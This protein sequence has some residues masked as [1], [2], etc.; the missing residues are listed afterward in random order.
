MGLFMYLS[1]VW[2]RV[3]LVR[4]WSYLF[5]LDQSFETFSA[6]LYSEDWNSQ[7]FYMLV[8]MDLLSCCLSLEILSTNLCNNILTHQESRISPEPWSHWLQ[9]WQQRLAKTQLTSNLVSSN[10][11]TS[12][13]ERN[14][15]PVFSCSLHHG[16]HY[17]QRNSFSSW[18]SM[19]ETLSL[20]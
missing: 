12:L 18:N 11:S 16:P 6:F 13:S 2:S 7:N 14:L 20:I 10:S 1:T 15:Q 8:L 5:I 3:L 19:I 17:H 9:D 4:R